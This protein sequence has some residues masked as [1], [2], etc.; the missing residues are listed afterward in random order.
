MKRTF[1]VANGHSQFRN[2]CKENKVSE[3]SPLVCYVEKN[4]GIEKMREIIN[5]SV[6]YYGTYYER[7]DIYEIEEFVKSRTRCVEGTI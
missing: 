7:N 5:P 4:L 2:W 6:V 3:Y 1:V